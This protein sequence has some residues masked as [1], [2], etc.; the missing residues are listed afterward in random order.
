MPVSSNSK[1][2]R[3]NHSRDEDLPPQKVYPLRDLAP[4]TQ[5]EYI[6]TD[7]SENVP[8]AIDL[9]K[10]ETRVGLVNGAMPSH[11]FPTI[12]SRYRDRKLT[13]TLTIVGN[14]IY[15]EPSVKSSSKSPFDGNLVTNWDYVESILDYSLAHLGVSSSGFVNNPILLTEIVGAP[16]SH[17]RNM[18]QLL[19]EAYQVPK[20][21]SG[22]DS[23][24]SFYANS[25]RD[26]LVIGTGHEAT[27]IIPVLDG[28][29]ILNECKRID[30]GGNSAVNYLQRSLNLKYPYFPSKFTNSQI[31]YLIKDHCYIST[32]FDQEM[33][34]YLDMDVLEQKDV[35]V[36]APFTEVIKPQKTEEELRLETEKRKESGRL[37]QEMARKKR[38]E[39]LVQ[40]EQEFEYFSK[41]RNE[42]AN[43]SKKHILNTLITEGFD[44]EAD[45][46]KYMTNLEKSLKRA[47]NQDVGEDEGPAAET[48]NFPLVD[49]PDDQLDEDEIKE[50]RK[51]RLMK[52]N[53]EARQRAKEEKLAEQKRKEEEELKDKRFRETD[54][55]GWIAEKRSQL[56]VILNKKKERKKLKEELNN[57]KSH[58]AQQRM[59]NI[60]SLASD[61]KNGVDSIN[62]NRRRRNQNATIDN[63]PNDTFGANDDDWAIYRD[64]GENAEQESEF[65]EEEDTKILKIE[66]ELLEYDPNFTVEDTMANNFNWRNSV[67]HKFLRGPRPFNQEDSHEQHRIHLNVE[68]IKVPEIMFQPSSIAGIDQAGIIEISENIIWNRLS[69]EKR[70]EVCKDIFITGGQGYFQNF[71]ERLYTEFRSFLPV[72]TEL[73][74]RKAENP[75]LDAWRGMSLW[76]KT[77]ECEKSYISKQDYEEMGPDYIKEHNLGNFAN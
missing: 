66:Q 69:D 62:S 68:R 29:G 63:D 32:D 2:G 30:W 37:L 24:F 76:S 40:K 65:E 5:P 59:K 73:K 61:D 17:R 43:T 35:C 39:K 6:S 31:D 52:S 60:A 45:F 20:V 15:L 11:R 46:K 3:Y 25:G 26:G 57:R 8:I 48:N 19:F 38:L 10:S 51:Q 77:P 28:K 9:G 27:H 36:E 67:V 7:Y 33:R 55:N 58:A 13:K 22:I 1:S 41:I 64:I 12:V 74:I 72:G 75:T 50:K 70:Y 47:R 14:D 44:D 54:L 4:T 56:Q 71:E 23:L 49:I 16:Q 53:F 21:V 18:Y 34:S 42:I